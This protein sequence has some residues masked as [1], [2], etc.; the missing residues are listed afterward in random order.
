MMLMSFQ[1]LLML[2][3]VI[4][5]YQNIKEMIYDSKVQYFYLTLVALIALSVTYWI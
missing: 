5:G 2:M 1:I 3:I 4:F